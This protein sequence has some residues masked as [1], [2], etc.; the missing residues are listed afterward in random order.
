MVALS[1]PACKKCGR[2]MERWPIFFLAVA[3]Q[4]FAP[5]CAHSVLVYPESALGPEANPIHHGKRR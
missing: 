2:E 5:T 1:D 4:A 3:N